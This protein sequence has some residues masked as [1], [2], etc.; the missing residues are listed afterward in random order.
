MADKDIGFVLEVTSAGP[1]DVPIEFAARVVD[2]VKESIVPPTTFI[3]AVAVIKAATSKLIPE[4]DN[5]DLTCT[6]A[7]CSGV[8]PHTDP[9]EVLADTTTQPYL[10]AQ[11]PP[12]PGHSVSPMS[13]PM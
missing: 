2:A 1:S 3:G 5:D 8:V 13:E 9:V 6:G 4:M 12:S 7:T 10:P 11:C